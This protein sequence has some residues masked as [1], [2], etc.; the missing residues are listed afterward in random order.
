MQ[1]SDGWQPGPVSYGPGPDAVDPD[2]IFGPGTTGWVYQ[3]TS[4][5]QLRRRIVRFLT[6][7]ALA[8]FAGLAV[9]ITLIALLL[10]HGGV[11]GVILAVLAIPVLLFFLGLGALIW[12]GRRAWRSGA[13]L[14]AVP[15]AAGV[16]WLSR[17]IWAVRAAFVGRLFWRLARR[18]RHPLHSRAASSPEYS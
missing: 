8:A 4:L 10:L 14:E 13:W 6:L 15:V 9:V 2:A 17:V 11:A 7:S 3:E 12:A 5:A 16:P 18:A 1:T